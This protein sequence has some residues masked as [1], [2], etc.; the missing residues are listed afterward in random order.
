MG[1][2]LEAI[3]CPLGTAGPAALGEI[4]RK[5]LTLRI[6]NLLL[7]QFSNLALKLFQPRED[8]LHLTD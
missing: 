4:W 5:L 6:E 2:S 7:F 3:A 1:V 8:R